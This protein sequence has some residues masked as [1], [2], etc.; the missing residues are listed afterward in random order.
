MASAVAE[1][2]IDIKEWCASMRLQLNT[3]KTEV[4]WFGTPNSLR[5]LPDEMRTIDVG[6]ERLTTVQSVRYLGVCL[7]GELSMRTHIASVTRSAFYHLRRLRS[8]G[9][10]L[11]RA[12]TAQLVASFVL[13]RLD[14]CNVV[15]AG[16]PDVSIRPLK[17]VLNSAARVVLG[18]GP[19][20]SATA[21]LREL[22]WLPIRARVDYKL[23]LLAHRALN[24]TAPQ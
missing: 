2:I 24:G 9:H 8:V 21:A 17:R 7:D 10:L 4:M 18:H 1:L 23:C 16:L 12:I 15:L 22:H 13:S 11:G 19:R 20:D 5:R 6:A 3:T 14:Y